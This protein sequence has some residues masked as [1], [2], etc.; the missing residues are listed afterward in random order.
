MN[1]SSRFN[2]APIDQTPDFVANDFAEVKNWIRK[3][4]PAD[5]SSVVKVIKIQ[6]DA[7]AIKISSELAYNRLGLRRK[8]PPKIECLT[9]TK[10]T[11]GLAFDSAQFLVY[12][13][14]YQSASIDCTR[15][16]EFSET[17]LRR[18]GDDDLWDLN[19]TPLAFPKV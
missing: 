7:I 2:L 17:E 1:V 11:Y 4:I 12:S 15:V 10:T 6:N 5:Y 8:L 18:F 3:Q 14:G 13:I 9:S 16:I 19:P